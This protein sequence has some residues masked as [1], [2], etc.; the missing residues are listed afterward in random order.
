MDAP[1]RFNDHLTHI[2]ACLW[3]DEPRY[4]AEALLCL[5]HDI[6]TAGLPKQIFTGLRSMCINNCLD[7]PGAPPNVLIN[8][9]NAERELQSERINPKSKQF[10]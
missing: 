4:A 1:G 2:E 3:D 6:A 9:T 8:L 7:T 10:H 5:A